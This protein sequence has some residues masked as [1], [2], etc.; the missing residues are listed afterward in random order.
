MQTRLALTT[1]TPTPP[2]HTH[3][4]LQHNSNDKLACDQLTSPFSTLTRYPC[5]TAWNSSSDCAIRA[6]PGTFAVDFE[7]SAA[8]GALSSPSDMEMEKRPASKSAMLV[9]GT[10]CS[11]VASRLVSRWFL[12]R[13]DHRE[14]IIST[15]S[16]S[17]YP[18]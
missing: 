11:N 15:Q 1:T 5:L 12:G 3:Q 9:I 18:M 16:I 6:V 10:R 8:S 13:V 7:G 4:R 17:M 2:C 14:C